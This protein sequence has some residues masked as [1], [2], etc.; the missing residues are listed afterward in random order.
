MVPRS[1]ITPIT[2]SNSHFG[3]IGASTVGGLGALYGNLDVTA[4]GSPILRASFPDCIS[5]PW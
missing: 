5:N 2:P 1:G 4:H 3:M